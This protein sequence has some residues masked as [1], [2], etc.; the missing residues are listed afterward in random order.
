MKRLMAVAGIGI[1]MTGLVAAP[2]VAS[3]RSEPVFPATPAVTNP[4]QPMKPGVSFTYDGKIGGQPEHDVVTTLGITKT[5]EGIHCVVQKDT[6][7]VSGIVVEVTFDYFAQDTAGNV[8]YMGEFATQYTQ[9]KPSG[10]A[11][12]WLAGRHGATGG[13]IMEARPTVGDTYLQENFP[14]HALDAA[15]VL[16]TSSSVTVPIGTWLNTVLVTKEFSKLE[17]GQ[18][19]HKFYVAGIGEVRD[20]QVKGKPSEFLDLT[21]ISFHQP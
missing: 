13:I 9:G 5:I 17:P 21:G 15:T 1:T 6:G 10:H 7:W 16:S 20:L 18:V 12:S 3:T 19:E 14:G 2:A 8:W 11:G 4:Y